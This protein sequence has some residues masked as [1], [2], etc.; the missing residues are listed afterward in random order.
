MINVTFYAFRDIRK[1]E[2]E[3][4]IAKELHQLKAKTINNLAMP[5]RRVLSDAQ[6]DGLIDKNPFEQLA[7]IDV[8]SPEPDPFT[9]DE[10]Y[11]VLTT[12]TLY[13]SELNYV[14]FACFSGVSASEGIALAWEDV[15]WT[16]R[17]ITIERACVLGQYKRPKTDKRRRTIKLFK[18]AY[19]ALLRQKALTLMLPETEIQILE[20][21]NQKTTPERL[22]FIFLNTSSNATLTDSKDLEGF[23]KAHLRRACAIAALTS[24][25]TPSPA[26]Y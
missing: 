21:R 15:N 5:L 22:R 17:T 11:A 10:L 7:Y 13:I 16:E 26:A 23:W 14:E 12:P 20:K 3:H 9:G 18:Q 25:A 6:L 2:L 1:T 24:A 4:W 8:P 19:A